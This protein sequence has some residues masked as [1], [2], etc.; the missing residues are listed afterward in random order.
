MSAASCEC[1][2][3]LYRKCWVVSVEVPEASSSEAFF[4]SQDLFLPLNRKINIKK[5]KCKNTTLLKL[6]IVDISSK[7]IFF[8]AV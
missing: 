8:C 3:R 5:K 7:I 2:S 6:Y 4:D 1:L